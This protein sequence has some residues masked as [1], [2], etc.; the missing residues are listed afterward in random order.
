MR[1]TCASNTKAKSKPTCPS[2]EDSTEPIENQAQQGLLVDGGSIAPLNDGPEFAVEAAPKA[3]GRGRKQATAPSLEGAKG[4][5]KDEQPPTNAAPRKRGRK[6]ASDNQSEVED[7]PAKRAK[8]VA[9]TVDDL[10]AK[11]KKGRPRKQPQDIT[12][13]APLPDRSV[14]NIHPAGQPTPRR[15]SKEVAAEREAQRQALEA[16]IREGEQA[17]LLFAQMN[18][19]E[20]CLDD[21]MNVDN[22]Q[23]LSVAL[24]KCGRDDFDASDNG[25]HFDF[26]AID[27]A[28]PSE[29]D[30]SEPV[31]QPKVSSTTLKRFD[32]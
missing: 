7:A 13:R 2:A 26:A 15:T 32:N 22:P 16:K 23:R 28:S 21:E 10:P 11:P 19:A 24:R 17:K 18:V 25:E 27:E 29:A 12:Q 9:Q 1:T 4:S 6:P 8:S 5:N 31:Q 30:D 3:K 20:E 14:R